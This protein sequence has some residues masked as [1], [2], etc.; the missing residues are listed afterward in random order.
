[1]NVTRVN[2][3]RHTYTVMKSLQQ[4]GAEQ[5]RAN[6]LDLKAYAAETSKVYAE[7]TSSHTQK[8]GIRRRD[9]LAYAEERSLL[10]MPRGIRRRDLKAYAEETSIGRSGAP[11]VLNYGAR[12]KTA[13]GHEVK[14]RMM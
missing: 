3:S 7:E 9:L 5:S 14:I 8:R 2:E 6:T 1:M 13:Q 4:K 11:P 10:R 12:K